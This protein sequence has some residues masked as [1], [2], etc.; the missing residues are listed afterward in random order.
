L[1]VFL[2]NKGGSAPH[3]AFNDQSRRDDLKV[4]QDAV[5]GIQTQVRAVP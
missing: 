3:P 1:R 5:L 4:A 2:T